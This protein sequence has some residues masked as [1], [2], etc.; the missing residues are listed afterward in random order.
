MFR[1]RVLLLIFGLSLFH[2]TSVFSKTLEP[3]NDTSIL[4][5]KFTK[6]S[7]F[8]LVF[9]PNTG[10]Y[11]EKVEFFVHRGNAT[12]FFAKDGIYTSLSPSISDSAVNQER[13]AHNK[14]RRTTIENIRLSFVGGNQNPI[15]K[16]EQQ[17]SSTIN[18]F[19]GNDTSKWRRN[20]PT[21][22]AILYENVYPG[23]NVR[24]Y[25]SGKDLEYDIFIQ[26]GADPNNVLLAY[27]G[28]KDLK[29]EKNGNLVVLLNTGSVEHK[30]P[31][32]YQIIN[33]R[34]KLV[35]G[36]FN[37][38][39][40]SPGLKSKIHKFAFRV[41]NF[42]PK[43]PI[44]IDPILSFS[45]YFGGSGFDQGAGIAVDNTGAIFIAGGTTSFSDFPVT[46]GAYDVVCDPNGQ[47]GKLQQSQSFVAKLSPDG[48]KL[49]FCTYLG[50][51]TGVDGAGPI[52]LDQSGAIYVAGSTGS[53]DFPV[54]DGYQMTY[55]GGSLDGFVTKLDSTGSQILFS[56][57]LGRTGSDHIQAMALAANGDIVVSGGT[58]SPEFPTTVGAYDQTCGTDGSCNSI[59][60]LFIT[61]IASAGNTLTFSTFLGGSLRETTEGGLT[62]AQDGSILITGYTFSPD[63]P[64]TPG[65]YDT[66]CGTDG[67]CNGAG[68]YDA[69]VTAFSS[70]GTALTWST[71]LGG[72]NDDSAGALAIGSSGSIFVAGTTLSQDFPVLNAFQSSNQGITDAFLTSLTPDGS[73]LNFSTYIGGPG[74]D[75]AGGIA[76]DTSGNTYVTGL[77]DFG[78]PTLYPFEDCESLDAFVSK[79]SSSGSLLYSSCLGGSD[80]DSGLEITVDSSGGAYIAGFTGSDNFPLKNAIQK[81]KHIEEDAF[82]AKIICDS[83][84]DVQIKEGTAQN[85]IAV[86]ALS[87]C[88]PNPL[89]ATVDFTTSDGTAI[90]GQDYVQTSGTL[91]IPANS[92]EATISIPLIADNTFEGPET[93]FVNLSNPVGISITD[94]QGQATIL[95]DDVFFYDDFENGVLDWQRNKGFWLEGQ[96]IVYGSAN[97]KATLTAPIPWEASNLSSCSVCTFQFDVQTSGGEE[98]KVF[99]DGWYEDRNNRV[100]LILKPAIGKWILKQLSGGSKVAKDSFLLPIIP[101]TTYSAQVSFDGSSFQVVIDGVPRLTVPTSSAPDGNASIQIKK[102]TVTFQQIKVF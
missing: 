102:T 78:F 68:N 64:S 48:S 6:A 52:V 38:F 61:E 13:Q 44:T 60:D 100:S 25:G 3:H 31:H 22:Q 10:Q 86:F 17:L 75:G 76:I 82:I 46:L 80:F 51:D 63:F 95:E 43:Y 73:A 35:S 58:G 79:F 93:F 24:F 94:F 84:D 59:T 9:V 62:I 72:S 99:L 88:S 18:Y 57:Y 23:I 90:A 53:S 11:S 29:E 40:K 71:F 101:G 74:S 33:G 97:K 5:S 69:F 96:G 54:L 98:S 92:I 19:I 89:D 45:T 83:I 34:K 49:I 50:G 14:S 20:I 77:G 4:R 36:E 70:D 85:G 26:P 30:K 65:A 39:S 27:E 1:T 47:C 55:G 81:I 21:F 28:I 56:T 42:N 15:I 67:A 91:F 41:G 66:T 12:L 7:N 8:Q 87:L 2:I 16:G 32:V 37:V